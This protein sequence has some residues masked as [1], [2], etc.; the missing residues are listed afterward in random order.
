MS[1]FVKNLITDELSKRLAGVNEA[2]VVNLTGLTSNQVMDLRAQLRK[3]GIRM[4]MVKTSLAR[5]ATAS[6]PLA[7]AFTNPSGPMVLVFGGEDVVALAKR[8]TTLAEDKKYAT[9]F[10][11]LGG[12]LDGAK[13]GPEQVKDVSKWPTRAEQLS[14]LVGQILG[15]GAQL[16]AALLG[17]GGTVVGQIKSKAE[18]KDGAEGADAAP[19]E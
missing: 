19:A 12:V 15:P 18:E 7:A 8:V 16:A 10:V 17:P 2:V 14:L 1:K 5:R 6:G 13:L 11:N 3:D 4:L 9:K